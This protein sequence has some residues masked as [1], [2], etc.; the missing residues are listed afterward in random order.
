MLRVVDAARL[1]VGDDSL[2]HE[3]VRS[4]HGCRVGAR[5][6]LEAANRWM[7]RTQHNR[8]VIGLEAAIF[9]RIFAPYRCGTV[10]DSHQVPSCALMALGA[11]GRVH[12]VVARGTPVAPNF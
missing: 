2:A 12:I 9:V 5:T 4:A 7:R 10:L 11:A 1:R 6:I 3:G 8:Q